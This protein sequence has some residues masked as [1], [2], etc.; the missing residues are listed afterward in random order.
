MYSTENPKEFTKKLRINSVKL[1][2]TK[3]IYKNMFHFYTLINYQKIKNTVPFTT[4]SK[5]LKYLGINLTKE[6]K[7]L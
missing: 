6:V 2:N 7:D 3:S 1:K 4:A 5:R